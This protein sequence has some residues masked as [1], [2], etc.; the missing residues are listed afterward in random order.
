MKSHV[1][2]GQAGGLPVL[3]PKDGFRFHCHAGRDCFNQCCRDITIFLTPYD[4]IR[5]KNAL[6]MTSSAFLSA[7]TVT[8][9][10]DAGLPV[11][12]LQMQADAQKSCP[13]VESSGCRIYPDRPWACRIYPLKP[14]STKITE[15]AGKSYYS[16]MA[17]PFCRGFETD[18][19][20]TVRQWIEEQGIAPYLEME[21][22]FK[23][24]TADEHLMRTKIENEKIR[25]MVY[26]SCYDLDRF[27]RF[28]FDSTFLERFDVEPEEIEAVRA[29]DSALYRLALR[30]LEFG[31]LA[32]QVLPVKSE[33]LSAGKAKMGIK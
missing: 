18:R 2:A 1:P 9:I 13:F 29:D 25:Q 10:G 16:V 31:L 30:W 14:E 6:N 27:R 20:L 23:K 5:M 4:I 3:T 21:A 15:K 8:L 12:V 33:V 28:V 32:Q 22:P 26:M 11:V 7:Y 17:A 24:I 19:A